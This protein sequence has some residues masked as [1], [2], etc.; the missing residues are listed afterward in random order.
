MLSFLRLIFG[1]GM[2]SE[3]LLERLKNAKR[4]TV[5]TGAGISAESGVPTFRGD[6]GLWEKLQLEQLT[7]FNDILNN[8]R[9]VWEFHQYRLQ[10]INKI[11]PNPGH[12]ALVEMEKFFPEF[13]LIT[14]NIDNLHFKAGNRKIYE[15]H[16]NIMRNRCV[17]CNKQFDNLDL[18]ESSGLPVCECGGLIRPDI[19]WFGE[20]LPEDTLKDSFLAANNA[21]VFLSVG[22]SAVVQPA[23]SLP[24]EAKNAGAYT[25]EIN[26]EPTVI[27]HLLH[28]SI[29]GKA[30]Q[31]LPYLMKKIKTLH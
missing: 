31:A 19:V 17:D 5:L 22:T 4:V 7:N 14:Q 8:P 25:V 21:D 12:L 24:L 11:K 1:V 6:N 26:M 2:F 15:L 13:A 9:L 10:L 16:G 30:G 28:E 23:A 3:K 20:A 18:N 29:L 27:S